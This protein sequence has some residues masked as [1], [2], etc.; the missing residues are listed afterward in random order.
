[1]NGSLWIGA[2]ALALGLSVSGT[3]QAYTWY[4]YGGHEYA[5]TSARAGWVTN[6]AEAVGLGGHLVTIN[7]AAENAWVSA[8]FANTLLGSCTD[9]A[10]CSAVQIGYFKSPSSGQWE[11]ISGEAVTYTN[12]YQDFPQGGTMAYLHVDGHWAPGTWNANPPH[13]VEGGSMLGYGVVERLA[14][15]LPPALWLLG[16][17]LGLLGVARRRALR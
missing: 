15:P 8:T 6:E 14:T 13:T 5:L 9:L 7:D 2:A 17:A 1:M 16:S 3:A 4:S 12:Y 11:W 10:W